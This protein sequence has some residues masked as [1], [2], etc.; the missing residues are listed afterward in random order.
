[1]EARFL[2]CLLG[3]A[4]GDALGAPV[5]FLSR[6]E[7]LTR[8]GPSGITDY[9][10]A[11]G[12]L[13]RITDDTQMTL[14]TAEGLLRA[15]VRGCFK[16]ITTYTGVTA[17]AYLRWLQTQGERS[18][19]E[20]SLHGEPG[21]LIG[22]DALHH[23]RAPGLT[24]LQALRDMP[25]LGRPAC[26]DS[27]GCGGVMRVAPAG[28]FLSRLTL[29][30]AQGDAF[31]LGTDLAALTHGHPTGSLTG[32]VL[33]AMILAL[34]A[35]ADLK[36][37]MTA[38]K[39]PLRRA[40][41]HEETLHALEQAEALAQSGL[42]PARAIARLGEGWVAEEALAIALYCALVAP[43]FEQAVI[44]AVNHDG[45]SDSTGAIVGNLL[46]AVHGVQA[47]PER[48]LTPLELR[49]VIT[50]L[51]QDLHDFRG[52]G[53]GEYSPEQALNERIW[54]KYPGY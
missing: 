47:I 13:G 33:A 34:V 16:G 11:Y 14:F 29:E 7:I 38:A 4:V 9:A 5:E 21:W 32:G 20:A 17:H 53:I 6:A 44:L 1:V 10:D 50:E 49:E 27:K 19:L 15:W 35:G 26:N 37:A 30:D 51:A 40:P 39:V 46:G 54:R 24:C 8:F 36:A 23:R 28:L 42:P 41:H 31:T 2:G 48:W 18:P 45:D 43:D 25:A 52:W 3:G 22:H 12:G